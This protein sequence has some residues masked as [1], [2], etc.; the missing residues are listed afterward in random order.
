M[1]I[2]EKFFGSLR[3]A[4]ILIGVMLSMVWL[5]FLVWVPLQLLGL[6]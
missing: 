1:F 6:V 3:L 5:A 4:L 2:F